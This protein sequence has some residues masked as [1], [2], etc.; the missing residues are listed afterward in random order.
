[1]ELSLSKTELFCASMK[2]SS[3]NRTLIGASDKSAAS[4]EPTA[5]PASI[6][7]AAGRATTSNA[8]LSNAG[9]DASTVRQPS[10]TLSMETKPGSPSRLAPPDK[11][12]ISPL[13]PL[14]RPTVTT[15]HKIIRANMDTPLFMRYSP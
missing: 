13:H 2:P 3:A 12:P 11:P 6:L 10:L 5:I 8:S 4:P 1:M 9:S 14:T 15:K 7:A